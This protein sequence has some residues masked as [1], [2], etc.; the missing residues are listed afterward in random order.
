[1]TL[2]LSARLLTATS[3]IA[4]AAPLLIATAAAQYPGEPAT[5]AIPLNLRAGPSM[6][7]PVIGVL[8]PGM[9]VTEGV[10]TPAGWTNVD[11]PV[12]SGW[13]YNDYLEPRY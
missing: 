3:A 11:S 10:T 9:P 5:A 7:A 4:M 2:R 8:W 6:D 12:G 13:A 1:M